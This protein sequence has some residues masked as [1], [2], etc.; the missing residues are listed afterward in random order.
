MM[1]VCGGGAGLGKIKYATE[2]AMVC[3]SA[4]V[5]FSMEGFEKKVE[6]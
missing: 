4:M 1:K 2:N 6:D 3:G 5:C